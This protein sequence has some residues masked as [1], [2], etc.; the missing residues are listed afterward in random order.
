M[1]GVGPMTYQATPK[2]KKQKSHAR[3]ATIPGASTQGSIPTP[4]TPGSSSSVFSGYVNAQVHHPSQT[5]PQVS[6]PSLQTT[7]SFDSSNFQTGLS[8]IST[9][10]KKS[11]GFFRLFKKDS[12]SDGTRSIEDLPS[13]GKALYSRSEDRSPPPESTEPIDPIDAMGVLPTPDFIRPLPGQK[14]I[15]RREPNALYK[16]TSSPLANTQIG[17]ARARAAARLTE[18]I[19]EVSESDWQ[20][21]NAGDEEESAIAD[22]SSFYDETSRDFNVMNNLEEQYEYVAIASAPTGDAAAIAEWINYIKSYSNG[23]FNISKPP[24]PPPRNAKFDFL[25]AIY[26][27]DEEMR[28]AKHYVINVPWTPE[29]G[30]KTIALMEAAAKRFRLNNASVSIF[31]ERHEILKVEVGYNLMMLERTT[32]ISAHA[33]Y[34]EDVF[35]ILDTHQDW[36]FARSPWVTGPPHIRF[37]AGAPLISDSG[38]IIGVFSIFSKTPRSEFARG[39]RRELAEFAALS[40]K[41]ICLHSERM[42]DPDLRRSP[43]ASSRRDTKIN[44]LPN[45]LQLQK[46]LSPLITQPAYFPTGLEFQKP[47]PLAKQIDSLREGEDVSGNVSCESSIRDSEILYMAAPGHYR[48]ISAESAFPTQTSPEALGQY[49]TPTRPQNFPGPEVPESRPYST[50]D[51]TSM[52][53]PRNNTPNDTLNDTS[54]D[55]FYS[56]DSYSHQFDLEGPATPKQPKFVFPNTIYRNLGPSTSG[57]S[58]NN[59][60]GRLYMEGDSMVGSS[61]QQ[62]PSEPEVATPSTLLSRP[63][64]SL[65][66]TS[67]GTTLSSRIGGPNQG[68]EVA[69][70]NAPWSNMAEAAFSCSFSGRQFGFDQ[71]Y[72]VQVDCPYPGI[73]DRDLLGPNGLKLKIL[74]SYGLPYG[75]ESELNNNLS[76]KAAFLKG[77]RTNE[78]RYTWTQSETPQTQEEEAQLKFGILMRLC[79]VHQTRSRD[80][81]I[82]Y[83]MFR[84]A[85]SS[86]HNNLQPTEVDTHG[87]DRAATSMTVLLFNLDITDVETQLLA[88]EKAPRE[89]TP[90]II[91]ATEVGQIYY[92]RRSTSNYSKHS[93]F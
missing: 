30:G 10:T 26:P 20:T 57:I 82:V 28:I 12:R 72:A 31:D 50:S 56:E 90:T 4:S 84:K 48:S 71:V 2:P 5:P 53:L 75:Y 61:Y 73:S 60:F 89:G 44:L 76:L 24:A 11:G 92:S 32:S 54:N 3:G 9:S 29:L 59:S 17:R 16:V 21:T 39:D 27:H 15:P 70:P 67:I 8:D 43:V 1:L 40:V 45:P 46:Q 74:A 47:N 85:N 6:T 35:V 25:P 66:S 58:L 69:P 86:S 81:G 38:E 37:F 78:L 13:R 36:R 22:S 65:S 63:F 83:A 64:S 51:L 42:A 18:S 49:L 68:D 41:D 52:D 55:T 33:L 19:S 62:E 93:S 7:G 80:H 79:P 23:S 77:L 34:S 88:K 87:L 14:L 91:G